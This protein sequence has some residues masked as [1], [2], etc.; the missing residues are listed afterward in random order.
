MDKQTHEEEYLRV[1]RDRAFDELE[2]KIGAKT[3]DVRGE[4]REHC[5]KC[6]VSS[7]MRK[8]FRKVYRYMADDCSIAKRFW[9]SNK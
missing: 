9:E 5:G 4:Q 6:K 3:I 8:W 7:A 2:K 1:H